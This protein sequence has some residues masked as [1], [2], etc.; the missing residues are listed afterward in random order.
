MKRIFKKLFSI[1][2]AIFLFCIQSFASISPTH[3]ID[4][5]AEIY[6][7]F[8]E[9]DELISL[10]EMD[11]EITYNDL[12]ENNS[13]LVNNVAAT[14]AIAMNTTSNTTPPFISSFLWGCI[15]NLPGMLIVGITSDF[16]NIQMKKSAWGCLVSTLIWGSGGL[17]FNFN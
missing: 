3:S 1:N 9:V 11:D 15:F 4:A 10:I 6:N 16:D 17:F 5:E 8:T 14:A 13:L 12:L 7:A 2:L